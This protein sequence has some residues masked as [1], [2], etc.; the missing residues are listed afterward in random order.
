[1]NCFKKNLFKFIFIVSVIIPFINL[2]SQIQNIIN[3]VNLDT[4]IQNVKE[5]SGENEVIIN[6]IPDTILSRNKNYPGNEKAEFLIYNKLESFGLNA[7]RL[8]FSTTG[9]NVY[10]IQQ[11][12]LYP[13][14]QYIICAHYDDYPI[15]AIAP[16][17]DDNASG[18]ATVLEAARILTKFSSD[19]SIIYALWDEEEQGVVG[20]AAYASWASS[21]NQQIRGVINIDMIGWDSDSNGVFLINTRDIASSY[22]LRDSILSIN[23]Y[24]QL[25]L[26][27]QVVDPG[28]GSDNLPFWYYGFGAIGIEED[29][30]NDWNANYHTVNDRISEFNTIYFHKC[31]KVVIGALASLAGINPTVKIEEP[32]EINRS[33]ELYQNCPNPFNPV[34]NISYKLKMS[35]KVNL[36]IFDVMGQE[37]EILVNKSQPAGE[38]SYQF[39]ASHLPSGL[40]YYRLQTEDFVDTKKMILLK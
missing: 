7:Q 5:L 10:A 13:D 26:S 25:G 38:Y 37:I 11:G 40:Y 33:F 27:P 6:G 19:Y 34:T 15:N 31:A 8:T 35:S 36:K 4:L 16:G 21:N 12:V 3:S 32:T 23:N 24:F 20:S 9:K 18:V 29:Y 28:S 2:F 14:Q 22:Q 17:A 39:K 30:F 1:M